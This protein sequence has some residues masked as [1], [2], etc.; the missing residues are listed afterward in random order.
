MRPLDKTSEIDQAS[1]R[2]NNNFKNTNSDTFRTKAPLSAKKGDVMITQTSMKYIIIV[3][4]LMEVNFHKNKILSIHQN[5]HLVFC[6][7]VL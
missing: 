5:I 3:S 7:N 6:Y 4:R 2:C 1:P